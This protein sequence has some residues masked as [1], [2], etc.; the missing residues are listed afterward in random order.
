MY[1]LY[2]VY[3]KDNRLILENVKAREVEKFSGCRK[4]SVSTYARDGGHI[5][6]IYTVTIADTV[7]HEYANEYERKFAQMVGY[8]GLMWWLAM[9]RKYGGIKR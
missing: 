5:K 1:Y 3:D 4:G 6:G 2:N 7:I 9:N 8:D